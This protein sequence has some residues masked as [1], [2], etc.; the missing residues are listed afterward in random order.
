MSAASKSQRVIHRS[1]L[2]YGFK[3]HT[4]EIIENCTIDQLSDREKYW[5]KYYDSWVN[6]MN[7]TDGG[8]G[9]KLS[10]ESKKLISIKRKLNPTGA[11]GK[12]GKEHYNYGK[13][14]TPEMIENIRL[15]HL[16]VN[17]GQ[18]SYK[19]KG[20]IQAFKNGEFIGRYEGAFDAAKKLQL[21]RRNIS[22]VILGNRNT[23]G[24]YTFIREPKDI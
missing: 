22:H 4:W 1:L 2:K 24:G 20:F 5:I 12:K 15:G 11:V 17:A 6:G 10:E 18:H 21:T 9:Y 19:F 3:A 14:A 8:E 7:L 23:V 16:G 13:K